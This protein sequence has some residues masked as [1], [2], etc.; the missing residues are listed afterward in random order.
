[1]KSGEVKLFEGI[2]NFSSVAI[3]A[4]IILSLIFSQVLGESSMQCQVTPACN[5]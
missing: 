2:R 1:M 4:G 5:G 3:L